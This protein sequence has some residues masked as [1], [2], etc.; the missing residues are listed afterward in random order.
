MNKIIWF[1]GLPSAGKT[2][3]AEE[4][5]KLTDKKII[6]LDGDIVRKYVS[7]KLGYSNK[8]RYEQMDRLYGLGKIILFNDLIPIICTNTAPTKRMSDVITIYVKCNVEECIK[9]DVKHLYEKALKGEIKNLP[10]I[11][12]KYKEPINTFITIDTDRYSIDECVRYVHKKLKE[13]E[14]I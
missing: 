7:P 14:L 6:L 13:E 12:L 4:L 11:D 5:I 8:D 3:L 9:R 10:G 1:T 2:T